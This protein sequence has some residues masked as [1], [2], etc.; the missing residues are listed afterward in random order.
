MGEPGCM[1][2]H[3]CWLGFQMYSHVRVV[4]LFHPPAALSTNIELMFVTDCSDFEGLQADRSVIFP[5]AVCIHLFMLVL[6]LHI[7]YTVMARQVF[8]SALWLSPVF[9]SI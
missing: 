2:L 8:E 4:L 3:M 1:L 6:C 5:C 9:T 7:C